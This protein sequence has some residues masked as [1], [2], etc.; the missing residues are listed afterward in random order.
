VYGIPNCDSCRKA[1]KW[2]DEAGVNHHFHDFRSD[3][4]SGDMLDRWLESIEWKTLLN[5]R[6]TTWR[7]LADDEKQALDQDK[8]KTLMLN[9]P[10]LIKRPVAESGPTVMVGF[11]P[12]EYGDLVK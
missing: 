12:S 10:T 8:A 1:R 6:S 9:H 2:L 7:G 11:T 4:V 3:G 5:T